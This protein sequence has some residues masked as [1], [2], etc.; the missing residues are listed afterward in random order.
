VRLPQ[1]KFIVLFFLYVAQAIPMSFFQTAVPVYL[2][3]R[4]VDLATL[5]GLAFIG[6]VPALRF[7]WAPL[8]DAKGVQRF[9]NYKSW[10]LPLQAI[11]VLIMPLMGTFDWVTSFGLF[12]GLVFLMT[13]V[14]ATQDTGVDGLVIRALTSAERPTGAALSNFSV[15]IGMALGGGIMVALFEAVGLRTSLWIMAAIYALPL[16]FLIPYKEPPLEPT[17][18]PATYRSLIAI[19]GRTEIRQWLLYQTLLLAG[20]SLGTGL[21]IP[22]LVDQGY[23]MTDFAIL[24]G[25]L[26]PIVGAIG[27]ILA[28]GVIRRFGRERVILGAG[29]LLTL[30]LVDLIFI[31]QFKPSLPIAFGLLSF[32]GFTNVFLFIGIYSVAM[33]LARP[34][35]AATDWTIQSGILG[36][37][38][39]VFAGIAG[40]IAQRFGYPTL[41]GTALVV[42]VIGLF[43]VRR[44][45]ARAPVAV[46][47][48]PA[49]EAAS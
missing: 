11:T 13:L 21:M 48:T 49:L 5:G 44:Y 31:Q 20:I 33:D 27:T 19:F 6:I 17:R 25:V 2:R 40:L 37:T 46:T 1:Y 24:T 8:V 29:A 10:I 9:G 38:G 30:H 36:A 18:K 47:A 28:P 12:V 26:F 16:I 34:E 41:L 14:G 15:L 45:F 39:A 3:Q 7:L 35:S 32:M 22:M 4:G 42:N 43:L 23:K